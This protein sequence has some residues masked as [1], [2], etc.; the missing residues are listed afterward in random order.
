MYLCA[1]DFFDSTDEFSRMTIICALVFN[2]FEPRRPL[3]NK[4]SAVHAALAVVLA[5][6]KDVHKWREN[7]LDSIIK[8]GDELYD[9]WHG[10][11]NILTLGTI[12]NKKFVFEKNSFEL[13]LC[14]RY[15]GEFTMIH[16]IDGLNHYFGTSN[17]HCIL[18]VYLQNVAIYKRESEYYLFDPNGRQTMVFNRHRGGHTTRKIGLIKFE[19]VHDLAVVLMKTMHVERGQNGFQIYSSNGPDGQCIVM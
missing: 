12:A 18:V 14:K 13:N 19:R 15:I 11:K 16:V 6:I 5:S 8:R 7:E 9:E 4:E 2:V 1:T 10:N 17:G 3:E